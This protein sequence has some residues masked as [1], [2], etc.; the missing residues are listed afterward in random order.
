MRLISLLLIKTV[1]V[2]C[3]S[4]VLP[5]CDLSRSFYSST[6]SVVRSC[7][8]N[9]CP[10]VP[11]P[12]PQPEVI[13]IHPLPPLARFRRRQP[14]PHPRPTPPDAARS[15]LPSLS[16][17]CLQ[18]T[19]FVLLFPVPTFATVADPDHSD[20]HQVCPCQDLCVSSLLFVMDHSP[21]S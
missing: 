17:S 12:P 11:I 3:R 7:P 4:A 1:R 9:F 20:L 18:R 16:T 5:F 15:P 10:R 2:A 6:I 21:W 8:P 13:V 14:R 19:R